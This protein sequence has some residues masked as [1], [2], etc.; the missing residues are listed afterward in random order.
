MQEQA[1]RGWAEAQGITVTSLVNEYREINGW[2]RWKLNGESVF[3]KGKDVTRDIAGHTERTVSGQYAEG[4]I[5]NN[6][7]RVDL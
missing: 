5:I 3:V 6:F 4:N 7:Y 1:I 2:N